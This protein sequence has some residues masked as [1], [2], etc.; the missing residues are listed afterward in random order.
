MKKVSLFVF[1]LLA[2]IALNAQGDVAASG[3]GNYLAPGTIYLGGSVGFSG[4]GEKNKT[5]STT[6]DGPS[7]TQFNIIPE[8]GYVLTEKLAVSLGIGYSSYSYKYYQQGFITDKEYELKDKSGNFIINP[9]LTMIKQVNN[10]FYCMPTFGINLGFGNSS[11]QSLGYNGDFTGEQVNTEEYKDFTWGLS[12][13][14]V[15]RYFLSDHFAMS[16]GY[17]SLYYSSRTEKSKE[18]DSNKRIIN[19]YGID[20]NLSS[21]NLGFI[22]TIN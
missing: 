16:L 13:R 3:D 6:T 15:I 17:G 19:T 2:S 14:P 5:S 1:A 8:V 11:D 9:M 21:L 18:N 22:Y 10:R 4:T 20:L 12:F 7:F